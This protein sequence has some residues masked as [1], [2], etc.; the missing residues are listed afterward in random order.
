MGY[1]YSTQDFST[2]CQEDS[3]G[4]HIQLQFFSAFLQQLNEQNKVRKI[5]NRNRFLWSATNQE[6]KLGNQCSCYLPKYTICRLNCQASCQWYY[7]H[8]CMN[9]EERF[10]ILHYL[11]GLFF[12]YIKFNIK[13]NHSV[14]TNGCELFH[15]KI[16]KILILFEFEKHI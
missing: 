14:Y 10:H 12:V 13:K 16:N 5:K 1:V 15:F 11:G 7:C 3:S 6:S 9:H 8:H 4:S 2:V